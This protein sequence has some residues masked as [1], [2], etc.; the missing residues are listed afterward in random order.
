LYPKPVVLE[1][2]LEQDGSKMKAAAN[3]VER[4][5]KLFFLFI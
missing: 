2:F 3:A 4:A 5:I 1:A